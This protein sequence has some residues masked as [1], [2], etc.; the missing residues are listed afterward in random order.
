[1]PP[2]TTS[3]YIKTQNANRM[4]PDANPKMEQDSHEMSLS[5]QNITAHHD[6]SHETYFHARQ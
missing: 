6:M 2:H 1:M 3:N 5:Q 4:V